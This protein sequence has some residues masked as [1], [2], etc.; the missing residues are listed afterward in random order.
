MKIAAHVFLIAIAILLISCSTTE[1]RLTPSHVADEFHFRNTDSF[2]SYRNYTIGYLYL[3]WA[4]RLGAAGHGLDPD[5]DIRAIVEHN[6]PTL[7]APK[8][9]SCR[10]TRN[11]AAGQDRYGV[12]L[13]HGLY[14]SPYVMHDLR[15]YFNRK[16]FHVLSMLLPGHG[17]RPGDMLQVTVEQWKKAVDFAITKMAER[18]DKL[19][20][21]GFS[22]GGA[23]AIDYVLNSHRSNAGKIRGLVLFAPALQ[24]N[25]QAAALMM[26]DVFSW[27][28]GQIFRDEDYTKYESLT[29]N[30]VRQIISLANSV[31]H[32]LEN[33][34][35]A[36]PAFISLA[37]NDYTI[38][39]S[40]TIELFRHQRF[41]PGSKLLIYSPLPKNDSITFDTSWIREHPAELCFTDRGKPDETICDSSFRYRQNN[42]EYLIGD[43]SH[44][45]LTLRPTDP[46]YGLAGDYR[47]CLHYFLDDDRDRYAQ[48][49]TAMSGVCFGERERYTHKRS[50]LC[51]EQDRAVARL[52]ANPLYP[53][54][55]SRLDA[56][57]ASLN[58]PDTLTAHRVIR[59]GK[60]PTTP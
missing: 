38:P 54:L 53:L 26:A 59:S 14:D 41:G 15:D 20:V 3:N 43:F 12:V 60:P 9:F 32:D 5:S 36:I 10:Q 49:K 37:A 24:I 48:C 2:E 52:T 27:I 47:Y 11:P 19:L 23:L 58:R 8:G 17:T 4:A 46:H 18:V 39:A 42:R 57:L 44:M 55:E 29:T 56:F 13:L 31:R 22:T 21:A 25:S 7:T 45:S 34:P 35:L 1:Q 6:A 40:T 50:R 51:P 28:P 30:S 33:R 16:C